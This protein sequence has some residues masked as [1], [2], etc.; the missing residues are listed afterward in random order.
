MNLFRSE[1]NIGIRESHR[2]IRHRQCTIKQFKQ[3]L[4]F[5][6]LNRGEWNVSPIFRIDLVYTSGVTSLTNCT[7][8]WKKFIAIS[9]S[10]TFY[11]YLGLGFSLT[12]NY[13]IFRFL[14]WLLGV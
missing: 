10:L 4:R 5:S 6:F 9:A 7:L 11:L 1:T 13:N 12:I 2:K 3:L 14:L 8:S